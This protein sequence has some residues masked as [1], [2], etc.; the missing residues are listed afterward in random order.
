MGL[1]LHAYPWCQAKPFM[2][3]EY[4][5]RAT[6]EWTGH[7][8][9]AWS[10]M[11]EMAQQGQGLGSRLLLG[12]GSLGPLTQPVQARPWLPVIAAVPGPCPLGVLGSSQKSQLP[13]TAPLRGMCGS[14]G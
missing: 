4:F 7:Q 3:L 8:V 14:D 2:A 10:G 11:G 9:G 12:R 1:T 5:P 6:L 13:A